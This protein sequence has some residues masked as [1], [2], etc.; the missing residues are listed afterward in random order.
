MGLEVLIEMLKSKGVQSA[1]FKEDKLIH[2][3]FFPSQ[4]IV[5]TQSIPLTNDM[6]PDD[7]MLFAATEDLDELMKSREA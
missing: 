7:V 2:V 6:P 4:P 3:E 1:S 5:Q